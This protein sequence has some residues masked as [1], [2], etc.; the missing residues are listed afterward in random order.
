VLVEL[1]VT[2]VGVIEDETIVLG[3][4]MTALTGETGAGKTLIVDAISLLTGGSS[5]PS[6]V[7]PG[8]AEARVEGRFVL[9]RPDSLDGV[10]EAGPAESPGPVTETGPPEAAE[11]VLT[12]VI[13]AAGRSRCYVDGRMAPAAE[14]ARIGRQLVDIHGQHSHQ[15]LLSAAA[16]RRAFDQAAGIDGTK[17]EERRRAVRRL[18]EAREQLG[19]DPRE[20][21]RQFD[22]LTYQLEEIDAAH[23][24][25]PDEDQVLV[26]EEEI[27]ADATGLVE[28]S[29]AA[30][31]ALSGD[32]GV[33]E[34]LG[35]VVSSL[36]GRRPLTDLHSRLAAL[37]E[38]LSD[39]AAEARQMAER[40]EDDPE[41]LA[42]IGERRRVLTELR[43]KYGGTLAEV[44]DYRDDLRR[45][46]AELAAHEQRAAQVEAD[47]ERAGKELAAEL[48][49][50][51]QARRR[52]APGLA[53]S[54]EAELQALA[55]P[56]ARFQIEVGPDAAEESV[57]WLLGANPGQP[58]LPLAKVASGGELSRT[59]LAARLVMGP[60]RDATGG[61]GPG[62]PV[63]STLIFDEVD[64]GIG[65]EAAVAV[66][67]ALAALG[68][69]HQVLVVTHLAQVAASATAQL[70]VAKEV[71]VGGGRER[72]VA[73]AAAV[74]GDA[75]VVELARMLSGRPDSD[76]ARRHAEELLTSAAGRSSAESPAP[77]PVPSRAASPSPRSARARR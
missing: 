74:D 3:A 77:S 29:A 62:G 41:R 2:N 33:G 55:M 63:P 65:G 36:A 47:L 22:L 11:V 46:V 24:E 34:Q 12:R 40:V 76:S 66:G 48:D 70:R 68:A 37:Q 21:A 44:I 53:R 60:A 49:R 30:W 72:T 1:R 64:A 75:R 27:L 61:P 26:E 18:I 20:R 9:H 69:S 28:T 73:T 31:E 32:G 59:M 23:L 5:D 54:V 16:Q 57:T 67:R 7:A 50:L 17:V 35:A 43:R 4:G 52:A 45:R 15:S 25:D 10:G 56:R 19:G 13:P 71:T 42:R 8:A 39:A 51:W 58:I 38:E 14:L 6:L